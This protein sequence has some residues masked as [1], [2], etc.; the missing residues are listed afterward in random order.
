[1]AVTDT[2]TRVPGLPNGVPV[3]VPQVAFATD[4]AITLVAGGIAVLTKASAGAYTLAAPAGAGCILTLVAGTAQAHVVTIPTA[5]AAGGAG[6]DVLTFGGAINDSIVLVSTATQW[7]I[8]GAP[9][10]VTAA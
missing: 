2:V 6:Q 1:M 10:N 7:L 5:A 4:G 9:R 3:Q 8:A